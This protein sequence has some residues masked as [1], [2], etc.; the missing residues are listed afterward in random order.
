[1]LAMFP[2]AKLIIV[3]TKK[4]ESELS[5][6][7]FRL[8]S[9]QVPFQKWIKAIP[10]KNLLLVIHA[11]FVTNILLSYIQTITTNSAKVRK[12]GN[13]LVELKRV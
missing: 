10:Q 3:P 13:E 7:L 6:P 12:S 8:S 9:D 11:E 5:I 4:Q 1:M 2:N